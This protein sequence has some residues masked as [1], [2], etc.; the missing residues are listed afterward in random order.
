VNHSLTSFHN[1]RIPY[2]ALLGTAAKPTDLRTAF[3]ANIARVAVGTIAIGSLGLPALQV[4]AF[5]AAKYSN[6]RIVVDAEG[7]RKPIM[8]FQT[9][10]IPILTAL[11]QSFVM[12]AFHDKAVSIFCQTGLDHGVR[13]AMAC[14][15]KAVMIEHAQRANLTLGDRCG[16]QGLFEV[17]QLTAM[18]VRFSS[19][20]TS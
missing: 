17:N 7:T 3:F 18:H 5:I 14:I 10:K 6:R 13:H 19:H 1:V 9:Q 11:A 20:S 16:A 12:Q 15:L 4:S 2:S 8:A